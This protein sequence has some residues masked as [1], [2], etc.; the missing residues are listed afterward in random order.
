MI[1]V[2]TGR[3]VTTVTNIG[4][5][6]NFPKCERPSKSTGY[7]IS[8]IMSNNPLTLPILPTFPNPAVPY[9]VVVNPERD[10]RILPI[11]FFSFH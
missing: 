5:G 4:F 2:N 9:Q 8:T 1:W 3:I 11:T 10:S 6:R 7:P